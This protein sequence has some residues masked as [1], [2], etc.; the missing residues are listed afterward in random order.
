MGIIHRD[1]KPANIL[2]GDDGTPKVADFGLAKSLESGSDLTRTDRV[3]GTPSYMAPE[4]AEGHTR[5]TGRAADVYSLGAIFYELLT[6]RPPFKGAT[7]LETLAQVRTSEPVA[8]SRLVPGVARDAETIALRCLQKEP[9][10]RY[11]TAHD[12]ADDLRRFAAGEIIVARRAGPLERAW[13]WARRHQAVAALS[14]ALVFALAGGLAGVTWKWRAAI[15]AEAKTAEQLGVATIART[16][17]DEARSRVV[18]SRDR[19]QFQTADLAL[20]RGLMLAERGEVAKGLHWMLEGLRLAPDDAKTLRLAARTNLVAWSRHVHAPRRVFAGQTAT[21]TSIVPHPDG[22]RVFAADARGTVRSWDAGTGV[23]A[24]PDLSH[25]GPV[26]IIAVSP[27]GQSLLA[28]GDPETTRI[29]RLGSEPTGRLLPHSSPVRFAEFAPDGRSVLTGCKDG[30]TRL[31]DVATASMIR[32]IGRDDDTRAAFLQADGQWCLVQVQGGA[33]GLLRGTGPKGRPLIH[34]GEVAALAVGPEGKTIVTAGADMLMRIWS[35]TNASLIRE[36]ANDTILYGLAFSS[37]GRIVVA[38]DSHGVVRIWDARSGRSLGDPLTH[39]TS[40]TSLAFGLEGL[41]LFVG[42]ADGSIWQWDLSPD[43]MIPPRDSTGPVE[44]REARMLDTQPPSAGPAIYGPDGS[45]ALIV[46]SP[47]HTAGLWDV[48]RRIPIGLPMCHERTILALAFSADGRRVATGS[49]DGTA[50][51][52]DAATG[53]PVSEPLRHVNYVRALAFSPDGSTLA[54]GG[55]DYLVHL[56]DAATGR[57]RG[58]PLSHTGIVRSLGFSPDGRTLAVGLVGQKA[59]V[60]N[61]LLWDLDARKPVG[62]GIVSK[63]S[64]ESIQFVGGGRRLWTRTG[65]EARLWDALNGRPIA[66]AVSSGIASLVGALTHDG[67]AMVTGTSEGTVRLWDPATGRPIGPP[68]DVGRAVAAI[69]FDPAGDTFIVGTDDGRVRLFDRKTSKTLGPPRVLG[70]SIIAVGFADAGRSMVATAAVGLPARWPVPVVPD[71]PVDRLARRIEALT[72]RRIAADQSLLNI[73]PSDWRAAFDSGIGTESLGLGPRIADEDPDTWDDLAA[74]VA[75]SQDDSNAALWHLGR[76]IQRHP[77]DWLPVAE[78]ARIH[79]EAGRIAEAA[80]DHDRA[81]RLGPADSVLDWIAYRA[82]DARRHRRWRDA[83][84]YLDRLIEKRPN[85]GTNFLDRSEVFSQ[86]GDEAAASVD[87]RRALSLGI[88]PERLLSLAEDRAR[89]REWGEAALLLGG[90]GTPHDSVLL[91]LIYQVLICV[92][93]RD[94]EG[95]HRLGAEMQALLPSLP[96]GMD[97]NNLVWALALS[98]DL[99]DRYEDP[100]VR[101]E[102]IVATIPGRSRHMFLNTLGGLVYR[103]GRHRDA[104]DRL[105]E[106]IRLRGGREV[107][108][109]WAFLAMAAHKLGLS[110]EASR[111]MEKL[112]NWRGGASEKDF[113]NNVEIEVLR[114]EAEDALKGSVR[115]R[116]SG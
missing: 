87:F 49:V 1:L 85:Q 39:P 114:E 42:L 5:T 31:W 112:R 33:V 67:A 2:L 35:T 56:W 96:D 107:P 58:A 116:P 104:I 48:R 8:P 97:V 83:L 18:E 22:R 29:W 110:G 105:M 63:G 59:N 40:V 94:R 34:R 92:K 91:P 13:N 16:E 106:G 80:A 99:V 60:P 23:K 102:R 69:A 9:A 53:R 4:Q 11:A 36:I 50:R 44:D 15:A 77:A 25:P 109:D 79:L 88:G 82:V 28:G 51:I 68:V 12:L 84:W 10:R 86:S 14:A 71:V 89:R 47:V 7:A 20:E 100:V 64:I 38:R 3:L 103:A 37:D 45:V 95:L 52:W 57:R 41:S 54:T 26:S 93:A 32:E 24:G 65:V 73:D 27:D 111:W 17:A 78:R 101:M 43:L 98:N 74:R 70:A 113:W 19:L 30:S 21:V 46:E 61:G 55:Y 75:S 66:P 62:E 115:Q 108:Q 6:G 72:G 81:L 76:L 90:A